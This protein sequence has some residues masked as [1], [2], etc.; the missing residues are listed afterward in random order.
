MFYALFL[1]PFNCCFLH[2]HS[3]YRFIMYVDGQYS[4]MWSHLLPS[5]QR[6]H[7]LLIVTQCSVLPDNLARCI[8]GQL[9]VVPLSVLQS[10]WMFACLTR[11]LWPHTSQPSS[12][13]MLCESMQPRCI[14]CVWRTSSKPLASCG[15]EYIPELAVETASFSV[16]SMKSERPR[17][18]KMKHL[19]QK[20]GAMH[21][22]PIIVCLE[23]AQCASLLPGVD[24]DMQSM[25]KP[26][27][28]EE[29]GSSSRWNLAACAERLHDVWYTHYSNL[30][31]PAKQ[32]LSILAFLHPDRIHIHL[33]LWD[34]HHWM[35]AEL[36]TFAVGQSSRG[37]DE[38]L[39]NIHHNIS[40]L[41]AELRMHSLVVYGCKRWHEG[42]LYQEQTVS[43]HRSVRHCTLV[44]LLQCSKRF[45]HFLGR[46]VCLLRASLTNSPSLSYFDC[47][48]VPHVVNIST[49]RF[50]PSLPS[51]LP[52]ETNGFSNIHSFISKLKIQLCPEVSSILNS[53]GTLLLKS[54]DLYGHWIPLQQ[55]L[56]M[57]EDARKLAFYS[58]NR[59]S[60]YRIHYYSECFRRENMCRDA[61]QFIRVLLSPCSGWYMKSS[62]GGREGGREGSREGG[63][64]VGRDREG[65]KEIDNK[66]ESSQLALVDE[67]RKYLSFEVAFLKQL[68][69][70]ASVTS[71]RWR[72]LPEG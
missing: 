42:D 41:V 2:L 68:S 38:D 17:C 50:L 15:G 23:A 5:A 52:S 12:W 64:E 65:E 29:T 3:L 27:G 34:D 43:L 69:S 21:G 55:Y 44:H 4:A 13:R 30:S 54:F 48:V 18:T 46:A 59:R 1:N 53:W 63:R 60:E 24:N 35:P 7:N 49:S 66:R 62:P 19:A 47:C 39:K 36:Y 61:C 33:L 11:H 72:D 31:Q 28:Q 9:E 14:D 20:C 6:H 10:A 8:T 45:L 16:S 71:T 57:F 26:R 22:L 58:E 56:C 37:N 40:M 32:L 70:L 25:R 67:G 51:L